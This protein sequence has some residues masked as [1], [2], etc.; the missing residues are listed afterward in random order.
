MM[1]HPLDGNMIAADAHYGRGKAPEEG[2]TCA[3]C[4]DGVLAWRAPESCS[5]HLHMPCAA[6]MNEPLR[7]GEC[8][9]SADG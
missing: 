2:D 7:C 6:C 9:E 4:G 8:G 5:C 3:V 1:Q